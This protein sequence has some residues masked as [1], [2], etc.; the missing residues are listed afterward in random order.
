MATVMPSATVT[1]PIWVLVTKVI[2][3][4]A[5]KT[6]SELFVQAV[7]KGPPGDVPQFGAVQ[8]LLTPLV[9]Q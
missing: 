3:E 8:V 1:F 4:L 6:A 7:V 2:S 9:F 5:L